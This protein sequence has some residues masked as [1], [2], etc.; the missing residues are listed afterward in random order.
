MADIHAIAT[1]Y[2]AMALGEETDADLKQAFHDLRELKVRS[3]HQ[4]APRRI[5]GG[6]KA[7]LAKRAWT[8]GTASVPAQPR[9]PPGR[10]NGP[11]I[12][13]TAPQ[14]AVFGVDIGSATWLARRTS[15]L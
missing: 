6:K 11:N 9:T 15:C 4:T 7:L 8:S 5:R 13:R 3:L 2:C 12:G 10:W 1:Y 14:T